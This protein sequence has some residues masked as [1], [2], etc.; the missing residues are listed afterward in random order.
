MILPP[1]LSNLLMGVLYVKDLHR[2]TRP[3][4]SQNSSS[5]EEKGKVKLSSQQT[6]ITS[7]KHF[8]KCKNQSDTKIALKRFSLFV[9]KIVTYLYNA[10]KKVVTIGGVHRP[11]KCASNE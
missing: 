5:K 3:I 8:V 7:K 9:K 4:P 2:E 11:L 6:I 10:A 1:L